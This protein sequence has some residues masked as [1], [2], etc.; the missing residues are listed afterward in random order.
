MSFKF[1]NSRVYVTNLGSAP[2]DK[3]IS[4]FF[5]LSLSLNCLLVIIKKMLSVSFHKEKKGGGIYNFDLVDQ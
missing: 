4:F 5:S 3:P 2:L 1:I